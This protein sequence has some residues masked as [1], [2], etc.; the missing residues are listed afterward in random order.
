MSLL[1]FEYMKYVLLSLSAKFNI[2]MSSDSVLFD[3]LFSSLWVIYPCFFVCPLPSDWMPDI[4]NSAFLGAGCS[5]VL[6]LI[7]KLCSG[8]QL[9]YYL[10]RVGS[11]HVVFITLLDV[12]IS[13]VSLGQI[14]PQHYTRPFWLLGSMPQELWGFP[15]CWWGQAIFSALCEHQILFTLIFLDGSFPP[16]GS[17]LTHT[18]WSVLSCVSEGDPLQ[19]W[20]SLCVSCL[21]SGV[22]QAPAVSASPDAQQHLSNSERPSSSTWV[23]PPLTASWAFSR[24]GAEGI[25]GSAR[26]PPISLG[27]LYFVWR[28]ISRKLFLR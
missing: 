1:N 28:F 27:S 4:V 19:T 24:K 16:S 20:N 11:F 14:I 9:T 23:N 18:C 2:S 8:T 26:L 17:F 15:V 25:L 5:C 22:L 6:T 7:L 13:M 10:Q 12:N 3:W 21:P